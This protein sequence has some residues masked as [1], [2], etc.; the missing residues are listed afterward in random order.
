M[1][2]EPFKTSA[3]EL[4]AEKLGIDPGNLMTLLGIT[5]RT[6]PRRRWQDGH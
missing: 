6:A 4:L 1:A 2:D 5:G 3:V